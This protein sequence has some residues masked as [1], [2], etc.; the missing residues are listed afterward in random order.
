VYVIEVN[1]DDNL[2][3][4]ALDTDV[5]YFTGSTTLNNFTVGDT[6]T[7]SASYNLT[8]EG[9]L[10]NDGS[11][12]GPY[13]GRVT[14]AGA[15]NSIGGEG[16]HGFVNVT[17]TYTTASTSATF[18]DLTVASG[19]SYTAAAS[20]TVVTGDFDASA[21]TFDAN[22]G[23]TSVS[24]EGTYGGPLTFLR[25][26]TTS[27]QTISVESAEFSP[28]GRVMIVTE[29][30]GDDAVQYNLS[31]PWDI[32]TAQFVTRTNLISGDV[33]G[34]HLKPDG[35]RLYWWHINDGLYQFDMTTPFDVSTLVD[36]GNLFAQDGS[37]GDV[38]ISPDG[39][40]VYVSLTAG[41]NIRQYE[42]TTPWDVTTMSVVDTHSLGVSNPY[43]LTLSPDGRTMMV[44][45]LS[46]NTVREFTLST[47]WDISSETLTRTTDISNETTAL[48]M[49]T[50]GADG[51]YLYVT[52][53]D[54]ED[55]LQYEIAS[56]IATTTG[57]NAFANLALTGGDTTFTGAAST[58]GTM[59]IDPAVGTTTFNA[60]STYTFQN[61]NWAGSST[62]AVILRSSAAGTEW[63]LDIPGTQLSV[64]YVDVEDSNATLTSGGVDATNSTDSGNNTN[65]NFALAES[66]STSTLA[67]HDAG[68]VDNAFSFQN[69]TNEPLFA[70]KLTPDTTATVTQ[71]V[72]TVR[73]G[74]D[75]ATSSFS[76]IYL[77]RDNDNDTQYDAG[78]TQLSAGTLTINPSDGSG[79]ITFSTD[80][81][82]TTSLSQNYVVIADW[83][84]PDGGAGMKLSLPTTGLTVVDEVGQQTVVG[85]VDDIHHIRG[86]QGGGGGGALQVPGEEGVPGDGDVTGG[87][88]DGGE[89]LGG[90]PNF[91]APTGTG[92]PQNQWSNGA[93]AYVS[94]GVYASETTASESQSY[95]SFGYNINSGNTIT[96]IEVKLEAS[97][98]T[99]TG[100]I[101]VA[102]SW[103]GGTTTTAT[104]ATPELSNTDTVYTLGGSSDTWG[105]SWS[106]SDF[107]DGNFRV[108][109]IGQPSGGNT[110]QVD[111]ITVR[112][113]N[114][115]TGGS[116]GGGGSGEI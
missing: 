106:P 107:T 78:D 109:I 39:R 53:W 36:S 58:T 67:E 10:Y 71:A 66:S 57:S 74:Q 9:D 72:I 2:E 82:A 95:D 77:Y 32:S 23:T 112:I 75:V 83:D 8:I 16:N 61:V 26:T 17:G 1:G 55:V 114:V 104:K 54:N 48:R 51:R 115:T 86:N 25:S 65:W 19:G 100:T 94:D 21:G 14:L 97:A 88:N 12:S 18:T 15:S 20:T 84:A 103:D 5:Q 64:D 98:V 80:F 38:Y 13:T 33:Q 30:E 92:D 11:L 46:D 116:G 34:A 28:D 93:N 76:N 6:A 59:T 37:H 22:S 52:E 102:L 42:M 27:G 85:A 73:G 96:G 108:R 41:S 110:L 90:E 56:Q 3:Q 35:T 7:V 87:T 81:A 101:E 99:G 44:A 91:E 69:K 89:E 50:F 62:E 45:F 105:R 113:H 70:F 60:S 4:Y 24:G 68:Q 79:S 40:W 63:Y 31:T 49:A 43:G 111:A 47:A 29:G